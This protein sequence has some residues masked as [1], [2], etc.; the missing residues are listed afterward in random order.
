MSVEVTIG[1]S[2]RVKADVQSYGIVEAT[3]IAVIPNGDGS[4]IYQ[5]EWTNTAWPKGG[6]AVSRDEIIEVLS[7]EA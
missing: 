5:L 6:T 7:M 2:T 4:D 1:V 3:V